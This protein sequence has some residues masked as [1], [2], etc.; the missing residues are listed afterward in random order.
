[1]SD[2]LLLSN[3]LRSRDGP[4]RTSKTPKTTIENGFCMYVHGVCESEMTM[5]QKTFCQPA[6]LLAKFLARTK[7]LRRLQLSASLYSL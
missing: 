5:A 3:H 6:T 7:I 1:M 2:I 4:P